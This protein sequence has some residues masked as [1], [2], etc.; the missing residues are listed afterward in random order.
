[1]TREEREK[2][3]KHFDE[4]YAIAIGIT[5]NI[6]D[7]IRDALKASYLAGADYAIDM[8]AC[9]WISVEDELPPYGMQVLVYSEQNIEYEMWLS[10]RYT[11]EDAILL[12]ADG[13]KWCE[14]ITD[15]N[16]FCTLLD[17]LNVTHWRNIEPPRK[18]D[19]L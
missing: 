16:G 10:K 11:A 2:V 6:P 4:L 8:F 3:E 5:P 13:T 17:K 7:D 14:V 15:K 1:M 12:G 9:N 19:E 18:E